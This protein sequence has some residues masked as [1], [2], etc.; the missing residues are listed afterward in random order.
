MTES[1]M[2]TS[3]GPSTDLS[4]SAVDPVVVTP[5][6][7][8]LEVPGPHGR[9][10][11]RLLEV[12]GFLPDHVAL[13]SADG[14]LTFAQLERSVRSL[15]G[16]VAAL[17]APAGQPVGIYAE[18]GTRATVALLAVM[19]AGHP[20]V[21]LDVLLPEA[22]VATIAGI[23]GLTVVLA[24]EP[25][26]AAASHLP[27]IRVARGLTPE[28]SA[29]VPAV[30]P[31]ASPDDPATLIFTSGTTGLPKGVVYSHRAVLNGA[32][33]G[34]TTLRLTPADRVALVMP[35][36]FAAGQ[37]L[38]FSGLLNGA[39]VCVR[40]PRI[41]GLA[42]FTDWMRSAR[43]SVVVCTPS[44]LRA[45][46]TALPDGEVLPDL[47]LIGTCGEKAHGRDVESFRDHLRPDASYLNWMGTSETEA[48]SAYEIRMGDP[49]PAGIIPAGWAVR[50]R[51]LDVLDDGGAPVAPGEVGVLAVTSAYLTS[52]YWGAPEVT[53]AKYARLPDGRTR[54]STGDKARV[55][56]RGVLHVL[57]RADDSVKIR[58]YLV[59]PGEVE[60]ALLALPQVEEAVVRA[61]PDAAGV[62][63]LVAWVV[64]G[65]QERTVSPAVLRAALARSLPDWMVPR[66]IV[67]LG[68]L[69]RT[70]RGK[71]DQAAL[72]G[73]P[74]RPEPV[75]PATGTE[76]ALE[77]IW[78][79][80][81]HLERVGRDESFSALGGDSLAVEEMLTEV[82]RRLGARLT[83]GDL[84]E[85]PSLAELATLVDASSGGRAPRRASGLVVLRATGTRPPL[86]C[87]AGAGGPAASFEPLAAAL[88]PDQPVYGLQVHGLENRGIPDWTVG[89]TARRYVRLIEQVVPE[90]P[91]LLAGHSLGGLLA[92]AVAQLLRARGREV[93]E[94]FVLDTYLPSS[95]R[96][97]GGS[98]QVGPSFA[99]LS[100]RELWATRLRV[101]TAGVVRRAPELQ[102]EVFHQ[103]G[104]R[105]A[106]WHRPSPWPGRATLVMS[107]DNE[108]DVSWWEPL[109]TGERVVERVRADHNTM[110]RRPFVEA[111]AELVTR[112]VDAVLARRRARL[113]HTA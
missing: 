23:A 65:A 5:G 101:L 14:L 7:P 95:A 92:L 79:S 73:V 43:I 13:D 17:G 42:D 54:Y 32:A 74:D 9:V 47:R 57:G 35:E 46:D 11:D 19:A 30:R 107:T 110:L 69:P 62:A 66:D 33:N 68:V 78:A 94:L 50:H 59:E 71:V 21:F 49:V 16:E 56:E 91:V 41:H 77:R 89:R 58:G 61:V 34:R 88:G 97:E 106:R 84:T 85:N 60:A 83:S 87:L 38:V 10:L 109:L 27:D 40:D 8:P 90:G 1:D 67:L 104:A 12:A 20:A 18:Q 45:L 81:L 72:P 100:A 111:L 4:G 86:F 108:D 113:A 63:R 51:Q 52:G 26:L 55:D 39:T 99:P 76:R 36:I 53:A 22:R 102:Q 93:L 37:M 64:P 25:R 15:A 96:G 3:F 103:H 98:H 80:V 2:T 75:P 29:E 82:Q 105:I 44:L 28:P 31:G 70:E 112:E 24:D 6:L 48:I